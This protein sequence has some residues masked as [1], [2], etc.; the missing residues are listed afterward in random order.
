MIKPTKLSSIAI[1]LL[2]ICFVTSNLSIAFGQDVFLETSGTNLDSETDVSPLHKR[3]PIDLDDFREI[4]RIAKE[5]A[6]KTAAATVGVQLGDA[7]ASGVIVS[8]DGFVLT[9]AHVAGGPGRVVRITLADGQSVSGRTLGQNPD[10]D[11]ALIKMNASGPWPFVPMADRDWISNP[12]DWCIATGHPGGYDRGR[13]AP[14]RLGRVITSNGYTLR[15]DC[16]IEPGDSGGPLVD[17]RGFVIGV[18]S[19]IYDDATGNLHVPIITYWRTWDQLKAGEISEIGPTSSFLAQFD[20]DQDGKLTLAELPDGPRKEIY[21]RLAETFEFDAEQPQ[22]MSELRKTIGLD[23]SKRRSS[24]LGQFGHLLFSPGGKVES[25]SEAYFTRGL[26]TLNVLRRATKEASEATVDVLVDGREA[27]YGTIVHPDGWV[28]SK[29]SEIQTESE[30]QRIVCHLHDS[31][32]Y[33]AKIVHV[34]PA[35]DL[36]WLKIDAV[37]L[38]AAPWAEDFVTDPGRFV[39]SVSRGRTPVSVGVVS[40]APREI[41]STPG[42]MGVGGSPIRSDAFVESIVKDSGA[43]RSDLQPGDLIVSVNNVL[44]PTFQAL[45]AE[46]RRFKGGDIIHLKVNREGEELRIDV[47]LGH[48]VDPSGQNGPEMSGRLS[49]RR[50]GFPL[51]LTHDSVLQPE[52]CGGPLID[53]SGKVVGLNISRAQRTGSLALTASTVQRLLNEVM[54]KHASSL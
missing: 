48:R 37:D 47:K 43:A 44:V 49:D 31:R 26:A 5:V 3:I 32:R 42:F 11:G 33:R 39:I 28:V 41:R 21:L 23:I 4:E 35:Y 53:L 29:A 34:D 14:V 15:S 20:L 18:H 24:R 54:N 1:V 52:E 27:A 30:D 19:R 17:L 40:V 6:R 45:T 50:D 46:V 38:K 9:A 13:V 16:P 25:L 12:G 8:A 7:Y 51:A 36:A 10:V 2:T 22:E